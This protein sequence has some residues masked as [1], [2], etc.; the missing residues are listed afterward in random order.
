[1]AVFTPTS[2]P[3]K[4]SRAPP[5]LPGFMEASVCISD[6]LLF[7]TDVR[8]MPET[9]PWVTVCEKPKGLPMATT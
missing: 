3:L 5:E 7:S 9:M 2:L 4:F 6:C 1:M 8:P